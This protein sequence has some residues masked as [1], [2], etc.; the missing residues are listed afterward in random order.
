VPALRKLT[1]S[2]F[3]SLRNVEVAL[4]PLNV[5]VG[6]NQ[7][8]KTN[9]LDVIQFLGDSVRDDLSPAIEERG[10]FDRVRFR[11][12]RTPPT[13][14]SI[15]VEANVTR[16]SSESAPDEYTLR[17]WLRRQARVQEQ[18]LFR[19]EA[20]RFK[21]YRGPGR[22]ITIEGSDVKFITESPAGEQVERTLPLRRDS[23]AL[24]TLPRL[25]PEEGG[26]EVSRIAELFSTFRIFDVNVDKARGPST[27]TDDAQ[28]EPDA[29]NLA[30][31]L[32]HLINS[33]PDWFGQLQD[34]ARRMIP[35]LKSIQ[36]QIIGG[37]QEGVVVHL[38]E[39]GLQGTTPLGE[40]SF[41]T[42]RILALLAMLYD[43]DP[44]ALTCVEEIDHG[45]HPY[46]FDL[47]VDRLREASE[48][49]QLLI[50][51][52]S[53]ALVNRLSASELIVCERDPDTG[54]SL[55]PAI[56][57]SLVREIEDRAEGRL[58]LGEI[59]F[60]GTLGGVPA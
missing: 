13:T 14:V 22:R 43:P 48:R 56:E 10:G 36:L 15:K 49:T 41:G 57:A 32:L 33:R 30:G 21:R 45:L 38:E 35:G 19:H 4:G 47:L 3:K 11:G 24:S 12:G 59:W 34:D 37:A 58:G 42:I 18:Y 46:V 55:I 5:L 6:P 1:V 2:N 53:P 7:S 44:P 60:S 17:F 31:F 29:S 16:H 40:A 8:G 39:K 25:D 28:L 26:S 9:F 23:L 27:M 51:T 50:V 52:H 20:F 54:E